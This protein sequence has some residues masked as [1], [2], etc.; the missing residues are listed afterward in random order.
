MTSKIVW[1]FLEHAKL[2]SAAITIKQHKYVPN[3]LSHGM[4]TLTTTEEIVDVKEL[5][6]NEKPE[7]VQISFK[8][9]RPDQNFIDDFSFT[10]PLIKTDNKESQ[11][12]LRFSDIVTGKTFITERGSGPYISTQHEREL[13]LY[14]TSESQVDLSLSF[15]Y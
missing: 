1:M 11:R 13:F 2:L 14:T 15:K 4:M 12:T 7:F 8:G 3:K 9:R 10:L 6:C 5:S